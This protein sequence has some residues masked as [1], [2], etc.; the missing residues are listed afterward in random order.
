[1]KR[2]SNKLRLHYLCLAVLFSQVFHISRLNAQSAEQL[3]IVQES[4]S[5]EP[6]SERKYLRKKQ[7]DSKPNEMA[8]TAESDSAAFYISAGKEKVAGNQ[9]KPANRDFEQALLFDNK[10]VEALFYRGIIKDRLEDP[11][12]AISDYSQAIELDNQS[13]ALYFMRGNDFF[14]MGNY[15]LAEQDYSN[16]LNLDATDKVIYFNRAVARIRL[17]ETEK[18]CTDLKYALRLGYKEA[19]KAAEKFCNK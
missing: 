12:N 17:G 8:R 16:A 3:Q 4:R 6:V 18:A 5:Y 15:D 10:N 19:G 9:W 2:E 13:T 7:V 11:I 1:M 14:L